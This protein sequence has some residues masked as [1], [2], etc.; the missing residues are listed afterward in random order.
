MLLNSGIPGEEITMANV[1]N[2][3]EAAKIVRKFVR[4]KLGLEKQKKLL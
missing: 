1:R 2:V 4:G 3:L